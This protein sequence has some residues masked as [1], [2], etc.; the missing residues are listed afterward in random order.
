MDDMGVGGVMQYSIT[1][2]PTLLFRCLLQSVRK[3]V[4]SHSI[5]HIYIYILSS[6]FRDC[7]LSFL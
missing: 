1:A 6:L 7:M 2:K 5:L 3:L 4:D